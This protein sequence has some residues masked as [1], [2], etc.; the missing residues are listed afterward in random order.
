[1]V[2]SSLFCSRVVGG[3]LAYVSILLVFVFQD[4]DMFRHLFIS[5]FESLGVFVVG[6]GGV[7]G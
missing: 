3:V 7:G 5:T 2:S 6:V 1:M 4:L